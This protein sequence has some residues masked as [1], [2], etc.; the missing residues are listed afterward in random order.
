MSF[1]RLQQHT[2]VTFRFRFEP[3]SKKGSK[4]ESVTSL[5]FA[6]RSYA[7]DKNTAILA[8]GLEC[9]FVEVWAVPTSD[10]D[11]KECQMLLFL[12]PAYSH[13]STVSKIAW[14]P[15]CEG[16]ED[17]DKLTLASCSLDR[18]CR[19]FEMEF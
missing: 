14:R 8:L 18:G 4:S 17:D 3:S 6:P 19:V 12:P 10:F 15:L 16:E 7:G 2:N 9:G 1:L 13:I 11:T 5:S